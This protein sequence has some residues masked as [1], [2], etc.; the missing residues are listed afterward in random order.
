DLFDLVEVCACDENSAFGGRHQRAFDVVVVG[1]AVDGFFECGGRV[2]VHDVGA[3]AIHVPD[4]VC[5]PVLVHVK[6]ND[7]IDVIGHFISSVPHTGGALFLRFR[8][9]VGLY[10]F[11]DGRGAHSCAD[12]QRDEA[13]AFAGALEFI[14]HGSDEHSAGCA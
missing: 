5:D 14:K 3:F 6:T 13:G 8:W 7:V 12:A 1:D 9:Q 2:A 4:E 11:D 10:A